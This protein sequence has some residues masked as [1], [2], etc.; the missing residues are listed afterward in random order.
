MGFNIGT[1]RNL[2]VLG[3]NVTG[4]ETGRVAGFTGDKLDNNYARDDM[5]VNGSMITTDKG[6]TTMHGEDITAPPPPPKWHDASWWKDDAKFSDTVWE[7]T[8]DKLP[9]LTGFSGVTQNPMVQ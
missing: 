2:V 3:L 5:L 7:L 1:I 4:D 9:I 8:D 6:L